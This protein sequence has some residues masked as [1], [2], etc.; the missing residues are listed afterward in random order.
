M[1]PTRLCSQSQT[2]AEYQLTIDRSYQQY[3]VLVFRGTPLTNATHVDFSA[4][5][6]PL[7]DVKPYLTAGRTN[8]F[9]PYDEIFDVSNIEDDGT[10]APKGGRRYELGKGNGLFHVDSS[11]NP[12]RAGYSLLLAHE[13][14]P[15]GTGGGTLYAD[16]RTAYD[17]LDPALKEQLEKGDYIAAHNLWHSR[18]KASP[19]F[20]A[21]IEPEKY[22]MSRHQLVQQ[23]EA[24]GRMNLYIANHIHHI[25]GLP[26]DEGRDLLEALLSHAT[27][28]KY[29]YE[30]EWHNPGDLVVWDNTCVM[31]R[32][33]GGAYEGIYRRD[34]RR[35]TVHDTSSKAWGLNEKTSLRMGLP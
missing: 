16:T 15:Q 17:Q 8:R 9:A 10:L 6:G 11:F 3:G 19:E 35:T 18:K 27:Q 30:F 25:E 20:F 33:A 24:S 29:V 7:D 32:A 28:E 1:I 13:L 34:M 12:R 14:P 22:F 4:L 21:D 26:E 23:H 31:H 5:F 2:E